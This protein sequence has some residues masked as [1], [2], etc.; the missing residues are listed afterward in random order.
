MKTLKEI[1]GS[2]NKVDF[3]FADLIEDEAQRDGS[4]LVRLVLAESIPLVIG[5]RLTDRATG[6]SV[7]LEA[8]DVEMISIGKETIEKIVN[9]QKEFEESEGKKGEQVIIWEDGKEG[10]AGHFSS[11]ILKFDVSQ[12]LDVWIVETG[13][14]QFGRNERAKRQQT[15][16]QAVMDKINA[17]KTK[18]EFKNTDVSAA[19]KVVPVATGAPAAPANNGQPEVVEKAGLEKVS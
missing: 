17:N 13:F 5:R 14:G 19:P 2:K 6:E 18:S 12:N 4:Q 3:K 7:T 11:K 1:L 9:L 10:K 15:Q 16:R 8:S